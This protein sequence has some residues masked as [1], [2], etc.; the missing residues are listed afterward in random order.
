[1]GAPKD[2]KPL[3]NLLRGWPHP[4]LLPVELVKREPALLYAPDDGDLK[5]REELAKWLTD[6]YQP[7]NVAINRIC[8]TGGASQSLGCILQVF[9]EPVYTRNIWIVA[10]AYFLAFRMFQDNGFHDKMRAVPEDD[11]GI[12][13][14]FLRRELRKSEERAEREGNNEPVHKRARPWSK[15]YR[16]ILYAVPTFSNPTSKTWTM[17]RREE[18]VRLA[19]EFDALV[20]T[21]DVYDMLQWSTD[22]TAKQAQ[23][24]KA[25]MP[26]LVDID[27][28]LDGGA[29]RDGA[30]GFGN[31]VSNGSFSKIAGPGLRTGWVEGTEKMAWGC[32]QVGTSRSGGA[33]SQFTAAA[34]AEILA[35]GE[36]QSYVLD[37]L[38]PSYAARYHTMMTAV[39]EH[40]LPLGLTLVQS[41]R[42]VIGGYFIWL[43]LPSH[44]DAAVLAETA[45]TEENLLIG[46][47][48]LFQVPGDTSDAVFA[49]SIRLCFAWEDV[50]KLLPGVERLGRLIQ[51]LIKDGTAG[52]MRQQSEHDQE[53]KDPISRYW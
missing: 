16:H 26:R 10:P 34:V 19:R 14:D 53:G 43:T 33:P 46:E 3:I 23:L 48:A 5:L 7:S 27:S 21:D 17:R 37:V 51:S 13:I 2:E 8:I 35:T 11:E 30:D 45:R 32:S 4:S 36:L 49:H 6:F 18:V 24:D 39:E 52:K 40:L 12:D 22:R 20:I 42:E 15:I 28:N 25:L 38:Q 47:G 41:D 50:D 44:I 31:A 29:L 1:M 9:T